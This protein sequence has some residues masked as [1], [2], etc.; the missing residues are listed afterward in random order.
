MEY[1]VHPDLLSSFDDRERKMRKLRDEEEKKDKARRLLEH[2]RKD[3]EKHYY[4]EE[5]VDTGKFTVDA[6]IGRI[7]DNIQ[8]K[9]NMTT[10]TTTKQTLVLTLEEMYRVIPET[11]KLEGYNFKDLKELLVK[12]IEKIE[13]RGQ[14]E[15]VQYITNKPSY[16]VVRELTVK[17][18]ETYVV[19]KNPYEEKMSESSASKPI[20]ASKKEAP[21]VEKSEPTADD[22]MTSP[23]ITFTKLPWE[24]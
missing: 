19:T 17:E 9:T 15:F 1:N 23:S 12:L 8:T 6:T 4:Y 7:I 18:A 21:I 20:K 10:K 11:K 24:T 22:L 3:R 14:W 16:F 5:Y 13:E 2:I